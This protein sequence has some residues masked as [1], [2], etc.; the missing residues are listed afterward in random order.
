M[1]RSFALQQPLDHKANM[2][3]QGSAGRT[4]Q[5]KVESIWKMKK[6]ELIAELERQSIPIPVGAN[7]DEV[8]ALLKANRAT[9][10]IQ[11]LKIGD[12]MKEFQKMNVDALNEE[13][14][15]RNI[16]MPPRSS[17]GEK[18]IQ[19][20]IWME[21]NSDST[22]LLN[23]GKY[24][25]LTY[26]EVYQRYPEYIQWTKEQEEP[27]WQMKRFLNWVLKVTAD[28]SKIQ[29]A[30][31][32]VKSNRRQRGYPDS[33]GAVDPKNMTKDQMAARIAQLET[34]VTEPARKIQGTSESSSS[35]AGT[36][37]KVGSAP[38]K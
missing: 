29:E 14:L 1:L 33:S 7:T 27:S 11:K 19:L 13:C 36:F 16:D 35:T 24:S 17:K 22:T 26:E 10:G 30:D 5:D 31:P 8:R 38:Q 12:P 6:A 15:S 34:A 32:M 9:R 4:G 20:R 28:P 3:A 25:H 37:E 2:S 18:L 21:R 23:Y